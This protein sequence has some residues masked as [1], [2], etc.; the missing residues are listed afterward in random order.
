MHTPRWSTMAPLLAQHGGA[1]G[2]Y[3]YVADAAWVRQGT[4]AALGD[5]LCLTRLPATSHACGQLI[6]AAGAHNTWTEGGGLAQTKPT[7]DRPAAS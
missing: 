7:T 3:S 1:P 6:A 4:R 5:T 2:A